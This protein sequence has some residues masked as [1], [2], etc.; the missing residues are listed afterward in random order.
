MTDQTGWSV[1][2]QG[3]LPDPDGDPQFYRGVAVKRLFAFLIDVIIVW[4]AAL[5]I[6]FLT[7][8]VAF[9]IIGFVVFVIDLMYRA[10]SL[11]NSSATL[12]M[13][14]VGIELR[15]YTGERFNMGMALSHTILF[16]GMLMFIVVQLI[17]VIMMGGGRYGR[18][19]HD[20]ILGST[21]INRPA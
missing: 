21:M 14:M 6:G 2:G 3:G 11:S 10:I 8:G 7:L 19:L 17:S 15:T 12:G 13:A 5:I 1:Y 16:Y 20:L 9:L 18:G 4:G